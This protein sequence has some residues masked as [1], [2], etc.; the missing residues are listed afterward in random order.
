MSFD[1][2]FRYF[3]QTRPHRISRAWSTA[4]LNEWNIQAAIEVDFGLPVS[5]M[6]LDPFDSKAQA[7]SQV[8]FIDLFAKPLFGAMAGVVE[9][10]YFLHFLLFSYQ[11]TN[12]E[13]HLND[14]I[15]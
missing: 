13:F 11:I 4:L 1:T 14:R 9:G 2:D 15:L 12:V 3:S 7:R 6:M 10:M 8:G 5:V